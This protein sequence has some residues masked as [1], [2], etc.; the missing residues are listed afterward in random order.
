[1]HRIAPVAT[2]L[3]N[4]TVPWRLVLALA[5]LVAA[6][7]FAGYTWAMPNW[8]APLLLITAV[9]LWMV[10]IVPDFVV[11]L[12]L[13][14][15]WNIGGVG[16]TA[17]SVSGFASPAWFMLLGVLAVG[18]GLSRSGLLERMA[19]RLLSLF[20][21]TFRGQV[22]ALL[23]GGWI[24]TPLL[25]LTVAR[26]AL[27]A[28]LASQVVDILGYPARSRPA[29]GIGLAAFVGSGLLSR[30][31]LSGATLNLIA[32]SLLPASARPGWWFWAVAATPT[33]LVLIGGSLL[34]VLLGFRPPEDNPIATTIIQERLRA[35]GPLTRAES[36]AAGATIVVLA[37]LIVGPRLGIDSAWIACL[38]P[39]MLVVGGVLTRE[40]FRAAIDWPLLIFLGVLLSMPA[41][42][43]QAALDTRIQGALPL[44]LDWTQGSPF[45]ALTS[46]FGVTVAVRFLLSEWVAVPVLIAALLPVGPQ[47]GLHPWIIAFVVLLGANL[48]SV[49]Y[50]FAS[51]LAFWSGSEGRLFSHHQVRG[52]SVAYMILSL[53]GLLLSVPAWRFLGLV[54]Y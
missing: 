42:M 49:P 7:G 40:Q 45:W 51:Y 36:V 30:V 8:R 14:V 21:A 50:Q 13:V 26:C 20:P 6:T 10:E 16:S 29:V 34:I 38:G 44:I 5:M 1:M 48:W 39:M 31:F 35:L 12:G 43:H 41:M 2:A 46:L 25:P 18:G 53:L 11:A 19:L 9:A 22:L 23:F 27:T 17:T 4:P 28:P 47:L 54:S 3:K 32:W 24:M 37:G 15:A 33:M 52:F